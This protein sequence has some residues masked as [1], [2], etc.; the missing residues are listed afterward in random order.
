MAN[1]QV[2]STLLQR[3]VSFIGAAG[4]QLDKLAQDREQAQKVA[5][6]AV[7]ALVQKGLLGAE[8][9]E[10]AVELLTG[11]HVKTLDTLRRTATHVKVASEV[12]PPSM[13]KPADFEKKSGSEARDEADSKFLAS[14]GF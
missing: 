2:D 10:A 1:V 8:R 9:K 6:E 4:E 3:M 5:A 7:D 14:L 12:T 11:D 13:G